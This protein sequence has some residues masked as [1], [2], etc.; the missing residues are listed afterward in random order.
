MLCYSNGTD[1]YCDTDTLKSE[2]Y[3]KSV[4]F[5]ATENIALDFRI[6]VVDTGLRSIAG[7]VGEASTASQPTTPLKEVNDVRTSTIL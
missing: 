3:F 7:K 1:N 2:N 4:T 6:I 5:S